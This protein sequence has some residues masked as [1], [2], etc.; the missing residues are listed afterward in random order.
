MLQLPHLLFHRI[1][2]S[3]P[4]SA[5]RRSSP[6]QYRPLARRPAAAA[7]V[8]L[9]VTD[10]LYQ[11]S[12]KIPSGGAPGRPVVVQS[13]GETAVEL[14]SIAIPSFNAPSNREAVLEPSP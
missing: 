8:V 3:Y 7:G 12:L 10:R 2:T 1:F 14:P 5:R 13:Q 11:P 9:P 6:A 4:S